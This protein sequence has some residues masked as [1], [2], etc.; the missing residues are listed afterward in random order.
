MTSFPYFSIISQ[1]KLPKIT[2]L[3]YAVISPVVTCQVFIHHFSLFPR[4]LLYF[5]CFKSWRMT[6]FS[7]SSTLWYSYKKSVSRLNMLSYQ[8]SSANRALTALWYWSE[9]YRPLFLLN[10]KKRAYS[11]RFYML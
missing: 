7:L 11:F 10:G 3:L 6:H 5:P 8:S 1:R 2:I 9:Y 4:N